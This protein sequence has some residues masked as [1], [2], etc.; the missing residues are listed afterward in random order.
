M[1]Q[2]LFILLFFLYSANGF[3]AH[4]N[5][6]QFSIA[7]ETSELQ[8]LSI[9]INH[10]EYPEKKIGCYTLE[11]LR[12]IIIFPR[13]V[14]PDLTITTALENQSQRNFDNKNKYTWIRGKNYWIGVSSLYIA[15]AFHNQLI[16]PILLTPKE[17]ALQELHHA[18]APTAARCL[19]FKKKIPAELIRSI[20]HFHCYEKII[21]PQKPREY[22]IP[23]LAIIKNP[24]F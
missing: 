22:L 5:N 6:S 1:K 11:P 13:N 16:F 15:N 14:Q 10:P 24:F 8:N 12:K 19:I 4:F 3:S 17:S 20:I 21:Y 23:D 2:L 9:T 18:S 7:N